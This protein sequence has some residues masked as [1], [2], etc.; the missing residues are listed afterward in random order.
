MY[1]KLK[2]ETNEGGGQVK[3]K[4]KNSTSVFPENTHSINTAS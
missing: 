1:T 3:E 2:K 4:E